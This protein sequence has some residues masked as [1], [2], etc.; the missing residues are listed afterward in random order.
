MLFGA[1]VFTCRSLSVTW[2]YT[3]YNQYYFNVVACIMQPATEP[4]DV[5]WAFHDP[6]KAAT[7]SRNTQ[8]SSN[9]QDN[10]SIDKLNLFIDPI[11]FI[12][13]QSNY[14]CVGFIP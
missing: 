5:L 1:P 7:M 6:L 10:L 4:N 14:P 9:E 11:V 12:F 3:V 2:P 8:V 13:Y